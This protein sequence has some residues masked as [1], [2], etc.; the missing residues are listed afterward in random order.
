MA[1]LIDA[2]VAHYKMELDG[3]HRGHSV[4]PAGKAVARYFAL[5]H[6]GGRAAEVACTITIHSSDLP[7]DFIHNIIVGLLLLE[8]EL[9]ERGATDLRAEIRREDHV[10]IFDSRMG[11]S[12]S[13]VESA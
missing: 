1:H 4:K 10:V 2:L 3:S 7:S 5:D 13:Q 12:R 8:K 6:V 11:I 9:L